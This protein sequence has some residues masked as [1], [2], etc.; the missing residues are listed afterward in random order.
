MQ[1]ESEILKIMLAGDVSTGKTSLL[2]QLIFQ[3]PERNPKPTDRLAFFSLRLTNPNALLQIWDSPG[4]PRYHFQVVSGLAAFAALLVFVDV[5]NEHTF[6]QA[7]TLIEGR[8]A[9]M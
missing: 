3:S 9:G 5:T 6:L 7:R 4:D 8:D 2:S 1:G